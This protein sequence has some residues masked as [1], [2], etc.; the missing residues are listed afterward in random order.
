MRRWALLPITS[1]LALSSATCCPTLWLRVVRDKAG[2]LP[3][4]GLPVVEPGGI[5]VPV[6]LEN[7]FEVLLAQQPPQ[8]TPQT[9][10]EK[11]DQEKKKRAQ[12]EYEAD[13]RWFSD[14][15][16]ARENISQEYARKLGART[17]II[18]RY[19]DSALPAGS[20]LLEADE[21]READVLCRG[22]DCRILTIKDQLPF[23]PRVVRISP[24][25]DATGQAAFRPRYATVL[26][27]EGT[28]GGNPLP[29]QADGCDAP[30]D[31]GTNLIVTSSLALP[32]GAHVMIEAAHGM[33][34]ATPVLTFVHLSDVQLRDAN[35]Y[36]EN[37]E[38][39]ARLDNFIPSF[40]Y[41]EDQSL[42]NPYMLEAFVATINGEVEARKAAGVSGAVPRF[43][44]HTGDSIDS[45]TFGELERF[46]RTMDRLEIPWFNVL[47]NHDVLVFGNMFPEGPG[48]DDASCV[49]MASVAAPYGLGNRDLLPDKLCIT[50]A[51][52]STDPDDTFV[53]QGSHAEARTRFIQRLG[54]GVSSPVRFLANTKRKCDDVIDKTSAYHG[55]DMYSFSRKEEAKKQGVEP[56]DVVPNR[57]Y[58]AFAQS[59]REVE[60][61]PR[62]AIFVVMNTEDLDEGEGG[63]DGRIGV[64]QLA[65]LR[66]VIQCAGE[67]DLVLL[68]SHHEL[69][70]IKLPGGGYL[71]NHEIIAT[72]K[73]IV[74]HFYG[75]HHENGL[76]SDK[77]G[78][79][80]TRFWEVE[81]P[82][83]IEFPQEGRLIRL[84]TIG[85]GIAFFEVT[86]F[87]ERLGDLDQPFATYVAKARRGAER[88]RCR[89]PGVR[90][91]PDGDPRRNDGRL[92]SARLF[93]RLP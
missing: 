40:E 4:V 73:N 80:C 35:V 85:G 9:D 77:R 89:Q 58:Y 26:D 1:V 2:P 74:G 44:I 57:G 33:E 46:H 69:G 3:L 51:I 82:S 16:D 43:L 79:A 53:A 11:R 92:A 63:N 67:H 75:H 88:D 31:A 5:P 61:Q 28:D 70:T 20:P 62:D 25:A 86:N 14:Q 68:F 60:G 76:C 34:L 83:L 87:T 78:N 10:D 91:S 6:D 13:A 17:A 15:L 24:R 8:K 90:C 48:G 12:K 72:S 64:D 23:R 41:D 50:P 66:K 56:E 19:G 84:K 55:F 54:H 32:D 47:G 22:T 52:E 39:S 37:R 45:G 36:V 29:P 7:R 65:W 59:L 49:W 27:C 81:G 38:I 21:L 93:F 18:E 71:R 30:N 42:Y